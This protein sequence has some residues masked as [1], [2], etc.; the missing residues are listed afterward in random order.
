MSCGIVTCPIA[1]VH[2]HHRR[3]NV[4]LPVPCTCTK[5]ATWLQPISV[6][7]LIDF[8]AAHP[9]KVSGAT[10]ELI[11]TELG[12]TPVRYLQ[13]LNRAIYTE[14][15]LQHDAQTTYRLRREAEQ[16]A[17]TRAARTGL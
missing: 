9:G 13:L 11:R 14:G 10:G 16:R 6:A 15:A 8:A 3:G 4:T 7:R 5:P 17:R 1:K 12:I 2:H